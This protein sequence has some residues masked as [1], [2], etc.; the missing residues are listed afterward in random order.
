MT[1]HKR[2]SGIGKTCGSSW[3]TPPPAAITSC[4]SG[5]AVR[6][7]V[8]SV[9]LRP[10]HQTSSKS[11]TSFRIHYPMIEEST[12]S[13]LMRC[14]ALLQ[15]RSIALPKRPQQQKGASSSSSNSAAKSARKLAQMAS[16]SL[17]RQLE[18]SLCAQNVQSLDVYLQN[19]SSHLVKLLF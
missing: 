12:S 2:H 14:G 1:P 16:G 4:S 7:S 18:I 17:P 13:H 6:K 5:S 3:I 15:V 8:R 11:Y 19:P 10:G 9:V